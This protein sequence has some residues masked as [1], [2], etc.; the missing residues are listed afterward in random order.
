MGKTTTA[1]TS[2]GGGI[3]RGAGAGLVL[4]FGMKLFG[5][6]L[7]TLLGAIVAGMILKGQKA[8]IAFLAGF[9][10]LIGMGSGGSSTQAS[11]TVV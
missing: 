3:M 4:A 2:T 11:A 6:I 5:P 9:M 10:L 1:V 7:G 8:L